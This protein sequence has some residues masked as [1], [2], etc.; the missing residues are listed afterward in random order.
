VVA[1]PHLWDVT[2]PAWIATASASNEQEA[3]EQ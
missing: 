1:K 3:S 2:H